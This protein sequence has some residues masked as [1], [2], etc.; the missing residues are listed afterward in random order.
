[1]TADIDLFL[2]AKEE[3]VAN[4]QKALKTHPTILVLHTNIPSVHKHGALPNILLSIFDKLL[5]T[6]LHTPAQRY[7]SADGDYYMYGLNQE[8]IAVKKTCIFLEENHPLG[9][10]IDLDVHQKNARFTRKDMNKPE[11]TCF[12]CEQ[13]ASVCRREQTHDPKTLYAYIKE[14]T[15]AFLIESLAQESM[16]AL[17]KELFTYPCFGLVSHRSSGMHKDM[18]ISHFLSAFPVLKEAFKQYL[19]MALEPD[20]N[21]RDLR[22]AGKTNEQALLKATDGIN[23]HKGAHFIFGLCL[24]YYLQNIWANKSLHHFLI[25][26]KTAAAKIARDDFSKKIK[27]TTDGL[28]A[29]HKYQIKGVRGELE[30]GLNSIFDWYPHKTLSASQ[31]LCKI[32]ARSEDTTLIKAYHP[33]TLRAIQ[34]CMKALEAS[35]FKYEKKVQRCLKTMISPGGAADLLALTFFFES[36]D[37]LLK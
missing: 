16:L 13:P 2:K 29:Y 20:F 27:A 19:T 37:H 17:R 3:R 23:T 35:E 11:R 9:R 34:D 28:I 30:S 7:L 36:T 10:F 8:A 26:I 33:T 22:K 21:L 25:D 24:P 5:K 1:M 15:Q 31:K 6:L 4:V 12:L 14:K 32:L 18:N